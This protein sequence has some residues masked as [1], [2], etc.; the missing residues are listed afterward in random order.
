VRPEYDVSGPN[1]N[2]NA[3]NGVE[4]RPARAE[5]AEAVAALLGELGYPAPAAKALAYLERFPL[6]DVALLVATSLSGVIG[7]IEV[8]ETS[9][10]ESGDVAEITGL[11]V[12]ASERGRAVGSTLL[13]A[14]R[15]VGTTARAR[16]HPCAVECDPRAHTR[17]LC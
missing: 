5:D 14:G 10:L 2:V 15:G 12:T 11:V 17:L 13:A 3:S 6:E 8:I 7:W 4:I 1:T 16:S 9:H